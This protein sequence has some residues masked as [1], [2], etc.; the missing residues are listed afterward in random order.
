MYDIMIIGA[1]IAGLTA[2]IYGRR[3]GLTVALL[4]KNIFGGQMVESAEVENYPG[5][6]STTGPEL[7]AAA[8]EQAEKLG[9]EVIY[10]TCTALERD[11]S[12]WNITG[13]SQNYQAKA[14]IIANGAV[15][16]KLG[17]DGE[18]RLAQRGVSYCATCDGAFFR[19]RDVAVVGGGNTALEDAL[20]LAN[21]CS[22]VYIIHRRDQFRGDKVLVDAVRQREN[23][24]LV[25]DS[26]VTRIFG[27]NKVSGAEV[28]GKNGE[29]KN[30]DLSAVFVAIGVQPDTEVF[31]SLVSRD[32]IGYIIADENGETGIEG[33]YAAGD[34]RAKRLRQ[35][36]TAAADGA[37]A[38]F[39]AANYINQLK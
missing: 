19:G 24:Q 21:M 28:T 39:S 5:V 7:A 10:D 30:I 27:E 32:S 31:A 14:V 20:F 16:R 9:A 4:E 36:V 38:A 15:H 2:A 18:E 35:I 23:I 3:A 29:T 6:P 1:G 13:A 37:N 11:G 34:C 26:Q 22:K 33:L 25:L 12:V 8:Y 17:C